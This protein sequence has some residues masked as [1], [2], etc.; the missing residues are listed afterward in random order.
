[1][2]M[3]SKTISKLFRMIVLLFVLLLGT[4]SIQAQAEPWTLK[5]AVEHALENNIQI[6]Q[7]YLSTLDAKAAKSE[8]IGGFLPSV[9][10]NAN[11][12]WNIGLNQNITT[13]LLEDVTTQFTNASVSVGVDLYRGGQ[14]MLQLVRSNLALLASQYQIEDMKEDV[15]LYVANG[16]LQAVFNREAVSIETA[17][18]ELTRAEYQR[19]KEQVQ[20]GV[21]PEGDLFEMEAILA[22]QEQQLVIAENQYTMAKL[23]LAQL[24][25][26]QDYENF[27]IAEEDFPIDGQ[28]ILVQR[29]KDLVAKA[30]DYRNDIKLALTNIDIAKTDL[31]LAKSVS[32]PG[33]TGFYS[34]SSRI[35]YADRLEPTNTFDLVEIGVVE[36]TGESVV[37]P[38][39]NQRVVGA[40]PIEEQLKLNDGHNFG[41]SLNIPILNGFSLKNNI[42]RSKVNVERSEFQYKQQVLDLEN[43]INQAYN[44]CIG[45]QQAFDAAQKTLVARE[46]AYT[47]AQ[48]RFE[49]GTS[50]AFE[51]SQAKL[52]YESAQSDW[53]RAKYDLI[54]KIKILELYFGIPIEDL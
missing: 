40:L 48:S 25:L 23:S 32:K 28:E 11:H 4:A 39:Y 49:A 38:V 19:T 30:L 36:P 5:R 12:S 41:L 16:Y 54:F 50:T 37:R 44:D 8:A 17:Q 9:N 31:R 7:A 52:Q 26:V 3:K 27:E 14:N 45:A 20:A 33:L 35:S 51:F 46:K 13:G 6:R 2:K 21:L 15:A 1:M 42:E 53:L 43:S 18:L 24:L 34:Y 22:S 29:P 47:Y 10:I